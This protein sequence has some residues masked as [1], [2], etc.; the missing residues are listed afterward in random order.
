MIFYSFRISLVNFAATKKDR[1]SARPR[2]NCS[3]SVLAEQTAETAGVYHQRIAACQTFFYHVFKTD[4]K[5]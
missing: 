1:P 2:K 3:K 5:L 4:H